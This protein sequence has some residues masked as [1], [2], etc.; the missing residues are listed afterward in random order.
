MRIANTHINIQ[1]SPPPKDR[2]LGP[3]EI[4][5]WALALDQPTEQVSRFAV[6][7]SPEEQ[8]RTARFHFERDRNRFAVGR[9]WLRQL[10]GQYL[11]APP[12]RIKFEYG[13]RGKPSLSPSAT[14]SL[15]HFNLAHSG[16]L[17]VLALTRL[18]PVGIDVEQ[19][20]PLNDV[21]AIAE[22]F[23]S[24]RENISLQAVA[25]AQKTSAFFHLWTRK[26]AWLKATGEG[27]G[28]S[29][30]RV[31][32]SFLPDEPARLLSLFGD[33]GAAEC[34][35]LVDLAPASGFVSALAFQATDGLVKCWRWEQ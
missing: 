13:A 22:R 2:Q 19:I 33:A 17:A 7:L 35:R 28:E 16:G 32:V 11:S 20:R 10:L 23:F 18:C 6:M 9:G 25:A 3:S 8:T 15:L 29:L 5:V 4:H 1:W 34:W 26:E 14:S 27:I 24:P 31:E 30:N 12:D 21:D